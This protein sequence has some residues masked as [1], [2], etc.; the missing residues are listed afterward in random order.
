MSPATII[1]ET[2]SSA[3]L[4]IASS[5]ATTP[6]LVVKQRPR[7]GYSTIVVATD[8]SSC[9]RRAL[10]TAGALFPAVPIH[11]VH[12]FHVPF[13]GILRVEH[14]EAECRTEAQGDFDGF[15]SDAS[16]P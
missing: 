3:P 5:E 8:F 15:W 12:A 14:N 2:T 11:L 16:F 10:A 7:S 6:V 1:W 9:S 13:E 4:W